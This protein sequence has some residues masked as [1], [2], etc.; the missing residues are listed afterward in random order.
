MQQPPRW[1]EDLSNIGRR[2]LVGSTI[3]PADSGSCTDLHNLESKQSIPKLEDVPLPRGPATPPG[4][5]EKNLFSSLK[6][7]PHIRRSLASIHAA[8]S[9]LYSAAIFGRSK[10]YAEE[11]DFA[12]APFTVAQRRKFRFGLNSCVDF[13]IQADIQNLKSCLLQNDQSIGNSGER[14]PKAGS[15]SKGES[16]IEVLNQINVKRTQVLCTILNR[17]ASNAHFSQTMSEYFALD[18]KIEPAK[19]VLTQAIKQGPDLG[20]ML[21]GGSFASCAQVYRHLASNCDTDDAYN[22]ERSGARVVVPI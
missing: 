15:L 14:L 21:R 20:R 7:F 18:E 19:M 16:F 2:A 12:V 3:A 10:W 13:L 6:K 17:L 22:L 9:Q 1:F 5:T 4:L 11:F 8:K